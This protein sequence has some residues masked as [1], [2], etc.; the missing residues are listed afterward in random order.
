MVLNGGTWSIMKLKSA[1]P[2]FHASS[3]AVNSLG[4]AYVGTKAG[5]LAFFNGASWETI[6]TG[7]PSDT[8]TVVRFDNFG[9]LWVGTPNGIGMYNGSSWKHFTITD[10][11]LSNSIASI[12]VSNNNLVW[13]STG[14]SLARFNG[15]SWNSYPIPTSI[16]V[17]KLR[18][19][20]IDSAGT[21]W[22]A[23]DS[24]II[25]F[26]GD[27]FQ[28][29]FPA[30]LRSGMNSIAV[31]QHGIKWCASDSAGA[32]RFN[33]T[34]WTLLDWQKVGPAPIT[35]VRVSPT[36][37]VW[38]GSSGEQGVYR[39][40][41]TAWSHFSETDGLGG[42]DI[43]DFAFGNGGNVWIASELGVTVYN[44][45]G[46]V[47][48]TPT[49]RHPQSP[50]NFELMQNF[51]NPF[52]PATRIMYT[53]ASKSYVQISVYN[54]LGQLVRKLV[55]Q[56]K[57]AGNYSIEFDASGLPSGVYIYRLSASGNAGS[58]VRSRKMIL[59]R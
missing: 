53:L 49:A 20:A 59:L 55:H 29:Y 17:I 9:N 1:L 34:E 6:Q 35:S 18:D 52:N 51:P 37:S 10:G 5:G 56:L 15:S 24:G 45:N 33:D 12:A 16:G 47:L 57:E 46:V 44:E 58:F 19:I 50:A 40:D 43:H 4:L 21:I 11:L 22:A 8:V 48:S 2:D 28:H 23:S 31:D 38:F 42:G 25:R 54:I 36:G 26:D 41:G 13:C 39:F 32:W 7:L 30:M 27:S 14:S 3:V